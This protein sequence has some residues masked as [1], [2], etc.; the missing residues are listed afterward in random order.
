[1]MTSTR[2]QE[3]ADKKQMLRQRSALLREAFA[4]QVG[5]GLAPAL[6]MADRAMAVVQWVRRHP[7]LLLAPV[8]ALLVWRPR[9]LGGAVG[10]GL[11]ASATVWA[12]RGLWLWRTWGRLRPALG[13]MRL[14]AE[15]ARRD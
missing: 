15:L 9:V 14:R 5:Q 3:L 8:V 10:G 11:V 6:G 2:L 12:G 13:A 1:M 7:I 4:Q